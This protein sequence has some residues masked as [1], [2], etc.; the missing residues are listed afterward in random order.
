MTDAQNVTQVHHFFQV[1]EI[2][3]VEFSLK[4]PG[5]LS[6]QTLTINS[7]RNC[8][9]IYWTSGINFIN[10]SQKIDTIFIIPINSTKKNFFFYNHQVFRTKLLNKINYKTLHITYTVTKVETNFRTNLKNLK[11]TSPISSNA[12]LSV[13]KIHPNF[14]GRSISPIMC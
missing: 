7:F 2:F 12:F 1:Y 4:V 11:Q 8:S 10:F 9:W 14:F 5:F 6:W 13:F 3:R